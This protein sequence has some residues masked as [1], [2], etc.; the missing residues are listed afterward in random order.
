MNEF[1][2]YHKSILSSMDQII[3]KKD[4]NISKGLLL[5]IDRSLNDNDIIQYFMNY[6]KER[7][8]LFNIN[9]IYEMISFFI[10]ESRFNAISS[11]NESMD[12]YLKE[13]LTS[14]DPHL[15]MFVLFIIS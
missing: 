12:H 13:K 1:L 5:N 8:D 4:N 2:N 11:F 14:S 6:L 9:D 10:N 15:C 3:I 7:N